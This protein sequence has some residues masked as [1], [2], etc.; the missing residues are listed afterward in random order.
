MFK[1]LPGSLTKLATV[2]KKIMQSIYK[3][4]ALSWLAVVFSG[5][6]KTE[7]LNKKKINYTYRLGT[8]AIANVRKEV[9]DNLEVQAS[10]PVGH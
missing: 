1:R 4:S 6:E 10:V 9:S 3:P 8:E 5:H 2:V 7:E